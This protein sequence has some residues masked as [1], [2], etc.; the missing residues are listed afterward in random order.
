MGGGDGLFSL[1]CGGR[2]TGSWGG[3]VAGRGGGGLSV[4]VG[5]FESRHEG[6]VV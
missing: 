1:D 4:A 6:D 2:V 3:G 5:G